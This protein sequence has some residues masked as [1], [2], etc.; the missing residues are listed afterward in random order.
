MTEYKIQNNVQRK[1]HNKICTTGKTWKDL[2]YFLAKRTHSVV[3]VYYFSF[4]IYIIVSVLQKNK[5]IKKIN[6]RYRKYIIS[7][8]LMNWW[9]KA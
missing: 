2:F 1:I 4:A 6:K 9:H 5:K 8:R 3:S 7:V